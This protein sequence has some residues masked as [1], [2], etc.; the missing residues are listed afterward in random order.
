[1]GQE[2]LTQGVSGLHRLL[3]RIQILPDHEVELVH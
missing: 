2:E 1:M 3:R